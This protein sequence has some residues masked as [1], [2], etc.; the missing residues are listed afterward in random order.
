MGVSWYALRHSFA[1]RLDQLRVP[2]NDISKLLGHANVTTTLTS[3]IHGD[4]DT[5]RNALNTLE[6]AILP[7]DGKLGIA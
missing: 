4:D 1:T 5:R 7:K 6:D 2:I 3:Y